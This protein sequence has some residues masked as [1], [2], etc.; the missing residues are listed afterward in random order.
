MHEPGLKNVG[1]QYLIYHKRGQFRLCVRITMDSVM[2]WTKV[3][4][5]GGPRNV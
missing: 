1:N 2:W 3:T 5:Y 4:E